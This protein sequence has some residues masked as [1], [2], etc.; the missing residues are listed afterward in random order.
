MPRLGGLQAGRSI[1]GLS[2]QIWAMVKY[3][4]AAPEAPKK[5]LWSTRGDPDEQTPAAA[6]KCPDGCARRF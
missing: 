3:V 1:L 6:A 5:A 4:A 2:V